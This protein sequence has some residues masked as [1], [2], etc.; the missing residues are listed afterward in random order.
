MDHD[1]SISSI[2]SL[3]SSSTSSN[4]IDYYKDARNSFLV[5]KFPCYPD[6][7]IKAF[8]LSFSI[9]SSAKNAH[10][11]YTILDTIP[12]KYYSVQKNEVLLIIH[13]ERIIKLDYSCI[14]Y[15]SNSEIMEVCKVAS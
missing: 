6:L 2:L 13:T 7:T 15:Y 12:Q 1:I 9:N 10:L 3:E 4:F 8:E 14:G 11:I 5:R